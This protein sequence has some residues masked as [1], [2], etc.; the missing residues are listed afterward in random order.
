MSRGQLW[1]GTVCF[2]LAVL[3]KETAVFAVLALLAVS[4]LGRDWR[5]AVHMGM[6]LLPPA[7]Y[8][9]ALGLHWG[10]ALWLFRGDLHRA[11]VGFTPWVIFNLLRT[12]RGEP[13]PLLLVLDQLANMALLVV[14][15]ILVWKLKADRQLFCFAALTCVP[16]LFLGPAVVYYNWHV[17]RQALIASVSLLGLDRMISTLRPF[18]WAVALL[19][20]AVSIYQALFW[21]KFFWFHK[22]W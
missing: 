21:S 19:M 15:F 20:F 13:L 14:L 11:N 2:A 22:F 5:K 1:L 18:L 8:Y 4:A 17:G 10:D 6:A 9:V 3:S 7:V 16:V 12:A